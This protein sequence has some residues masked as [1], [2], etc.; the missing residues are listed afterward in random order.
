MITELT[1][2]LRGQAGPRLV[3]GAKTPF[4]TTRDIDGVNVIV[5]KR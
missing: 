4:S 5:L 1:L 2:Q 3:N